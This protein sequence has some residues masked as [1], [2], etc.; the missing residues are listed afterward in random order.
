[1][2]LWLLVLGSARERDRS[3]CPP[4]NSWRSRYPGAPQRL[5]SLPMTAAISPDGRYLAVVNAG[6]GTF[7][8]R[9][10]QSIAVL[11]IQP[12]RSRISPNREQRRGCRKHC[13]P[14]WPSVRTARICM[15]FSIPSPRPGEQQ[16]RDRQCHRRLRIQQRQGKATAIASRSLA[17]IGPGKAAK[18]DRASLCPQAPRSPRRPASQSARDRTG[19]MNCWSQTISPTMFC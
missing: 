5:N 12:A 4:A 2:I 3:T 16:R 1:M 10:Q 9:Y 17:A 15:R 19:S 8:S 18:S 13:I 7:E 6:Y 11:D 14:G